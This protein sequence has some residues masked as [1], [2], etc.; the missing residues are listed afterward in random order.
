VNVKTILTGCLLLCLGLA[1]RSQAQT[2]TLQAVA[3]STLKQSPA[4]KNRGSDPTLELA[5]DG[6][7]LVLFD[8]AAIT[9]AVGSG[10]LVSASL[11]LFVHSTSGSWGPDGRPIEPHLVTA[12][13]TEAGVTW[14]CAVDANPAN[15]KQDCASPWNGGSFADDATDSVVQ[16][17]TEQVWMPFDVTADVAAFLGGTPNQGWLIGKADDDQS[18]KADYGSRE[19][20]AAERPR[21]VL[22]VES[23]AHDQVPPSLAITSPNQPIMVNDPAPTVIVEYSDGGSGVDLTTLQVLA[24]GQSITTGCAA[25]AQSATCHAP[26]LAAGNHTVQ[27]SLRD[28]AGNAAQA[29]A[30]FQLLLGPGPHLVTLQASGDTYLKKGAANKNFGS[31]PILRVRESGQHRALVQFDGASLAN[32]LRGAT[33]VSASLELH[34][35]KNGRNWGKTGR[36]V[37]AHRLTSAWTE[38]GATWNCPNDSN[39]TNGNPDCAAQWGGGSFAS[40]PTASVLHTRDLTGWVPYD[41]TADVAAF[42]TGAPNFG[43]LLKKTDETKSGWVDYDSREGTPGEGPRLLV[44]FTTPT[45]GDTTPPNLAITAPANGA[46]VNTP[47]LHVTG[48]ASDDGVVARVTVNGI[49]ATVSNGQFAADVPLFLGANEVTVQ[50]VDASGN[51]AFAVATVTLDTQPPSLIVEAPIDGQLTNVTVVRVAGRAEDDNGIAGVDV[52]GVAIPAAGGVFEGSFPLAEGDNHLTIRALDVA[53]NAQ[54]V[55]VSVRRF[56]LPTVSITTPADLSILAAT[57]TEV[58]G[59]VTSGS[60]VKVNGVPAL[61]TG[62]T[63]VA[64]DVPLIEG[65]N[66]LTAAAT[67]ALGHVGTATIHLVR[68]LTPPRVA[69]QFPQA[70]ARLTETAVTVTGLVN[71]IV[72]GTVNAMQASVT[73]NGRPATVA[74]RSFEAAGVPLSPGDN[75]LTAVATDAS[76]NRGETSITVRLETGVPR[77][78]VLSGDRQ[79]GTIGSLLPQPLTVALLDSAGLPVAGKPVLFKVRGSNGALDG[80]RRQIAV[81]SGPDGRAAAHFTLGSRAGVGNQAVEVSAAGFA[82]AL[83]TASAHPSAPALIVEDAGDQ[84]VGV[85]GQKLPRPLVAAV[86]DAGFNRLGG[87]LVRFTVVKGQGH[88]ENGA[89]DALLPTD[90]DGRAILSLVLDTQEGIASNVVKAQIDAL[91]AGPMVSF[92]ATGRAAGD[93]ALTAISGVVLDNTDTPIT[94]VTLRVLDSPLIARTDAQGQF[95]INGAPVGTVKLIVD[96]STAERPGSWPD[97]EFVLATVPGRNNTVGMPIFLLPLNQQAEISVDETRGGTLTLPEVPG[98]ALEVSPGSVTFPGGSRSGVVSVTAVHGDKVPMVPNFGQQPRFIVTIQPAGARFDPPA[99]LT[100]PNVEG[101]APGEVTEMYSFDHD[102]GHFVS[103]GPA[104]VSDDGTVIVANPGVGVV[105]AGWHCGGNAGGT[106]TTHNCPA[107]QKCV[108]DC[109]VPEALC[110]KSTC[111]AG[112]ACDGTGTCKTGKALIPKICNQL[113]LTYANQ[114]TLGCGTSCGAQI[115]YSVTGVTNS[116]DT[117]DLVGA[118]VTE[119]VTTDAKCLPGGVQTGAGCPVGSGNSITGCTDTY[120]LC[121][122]AASFQI[123]TCTETYTQKLYVDGCLAETRRIVFTVTRTAT[124]CS[125]TVTR[126]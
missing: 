93:A 23:A 73:V 77:L 123:G 80:G 27:A 76:G 8:Q 117:I 103:I 126:N 16:T 28:H 115:R 53:G 12:G 61:V 113:H 106:G 63:F 17:S 108:N 78:S 7:V 37:E 9:A 42:A 30:A 66:I 36:T 119:S 114:Q 51:Q 4:N 98:F 121:A 82:G 25:G 48:T 112:S 70:G 79:E 90:S 56:T 92:T 39:T 3:D 65:G 111:A 59:T 20:A 89:Q 47:T 91:P 57:T 71:D 55:A 120:G 85:T 124:S 67:D 14:N 19:G 110:T 62:T 100:L 54:Q 84:Q 95:Q 122:A 87:V 35:E 109:C 102:L 107:C 26:T 97:L 2:V 88:F 6:R 64:A 1:A 99:R 105:K 21:L 32:T 101:L 74:N 104:T 22:L 45:T 29:S 72:P 83:F 81:T 40:T 118:K 86:T 43:W 31:E 58:Q 60:T 46:F 52:N 44:V 13:W 38:T 116:C 11:E 34:V 41:I 69:I 18:G 49:A 75:V 5:G 10:R 15:N 94:G 24:D 33:V 125:G 50:A 68:D 96:G